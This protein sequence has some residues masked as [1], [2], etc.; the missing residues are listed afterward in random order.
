MSFKFPPT[1]KAQ[2]TKAVTMSGNNAWDVGAVAAPSCSPN[3]GVLSDMESPQL[4]LGSHLGRG[5]L[6][7]TICLEQWSP[8]CG[9]QATDGPWVLK[10]W[11]Q[12]VWNIHRIHM[13]TLWCL[14]CLKHPWGDAPGQWHSLGALETLASHSYHRVTDKSQERRFGHFGSQNLPLW[15][16]SSYF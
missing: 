10:G 14:R 3:Y 11:R 1:T 2:M 8:T 15:A 16:L 6:Q 12:L 7:L 9:L 13:D 4:L 5:I